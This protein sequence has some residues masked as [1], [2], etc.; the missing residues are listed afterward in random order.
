MLGDTLFRVTFSSSDEVLYFFI[1]LFLYFCIF[2]AMFTWLDLM[3]FTCLEL[4]MRPIT[5]RP[6]SK[7]SSVGRFNGQATRVHRANIRVVNR[8]G[9]RF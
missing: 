5:R 8:G 4:F 3:L 6:V 2:C 7:R 1:L 9:I